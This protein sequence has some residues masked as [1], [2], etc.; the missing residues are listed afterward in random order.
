MNAIGSVD[1]IGFEKTV[2]F[3]KNS[4]FFSMMPENRLR[5]ISRESAVVKLCP[6]GRLFEQGDTGDA[7]YLVLDGVISVEVA[8]ESGRAVVAT[9]GPGEL[10][11]EIA[12]FSNLKRNAS[13]FSETGAHLLHIGQDT[14][15]DMLQ[16][17]PSCAMNIIVELGARLDS[18]NNSI[19]V[20]CHAANALA[21]GD[22]KPD[23]L[24]ALKQGADR[25]SHFAKV[26]ESM[27]SE[28]TTKH[29]FLQ[30]INTAKIIQRSFLPK[31]IDAGDRGG[32]FRIAAEMLPAKEVG[33][34]FFDYFMIDDR[35]LG[36]AVGDVSGK[37]IPA[38]IFMSVTRTMLR[39][40]A[41]QGGKAGDVVTQLNSLLAEDNSESMFVTLAC[42]RLDLDTGQFDYANAAH[43]EAYVLRADGS[44]NHI[45][46]M[47]PAVGL[48]DGIWYQSD[49]RIL[50]PGDTILL[51][52][53]G[54]T[55]AFSAQGVM[56]GTD[57]FTALMKRLGRE[58]VDN[59]VRQI[60][61]EV[62]QF[63]HGVPQSDDLTCLAA[64]YFG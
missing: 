44:L 51:G 32:Q 23:M 37:G 35:N 1:T 9:V 24:S 53:D 47:G 15:R 56:Y 14:I 22:F 43:E 28:I 41:R 58:P 39:T 25:F 64:R 36:I 33:G 17:D 27:A 10:V 29:Q 3:L 7:A 4:R 59:V 62:M 49:T 55:E 8:T 5:D 54:I 20:L 61:G 6:G 57:R 42:G 11:G 63:S 40:I 21:A 34:D 48:F 13:V 46:P 2:G 16:R 45:G 50:K 12:V 30:E 31:R 52:T 19:A 60:T 38:A 26:F 18:N